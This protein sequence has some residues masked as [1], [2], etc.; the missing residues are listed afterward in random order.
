[1]GVNAVLLGT[2][3]VGVRRLAGGEG[4]HPDLI[5]VLQSWSDQFSESDVHDLI[6]HCPLARIVCCFG[7]WCDSD[8]RTRSI[9]PLAVRVPV[10]AASTRLER[11]L[12][13]LQHHQSAS[14]PLPLTA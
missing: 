10:A 4:W 11:E 3:L 1:M 8:G 7:P 13:L 5:V 6:A 14:R 2:D 12:A 9:W